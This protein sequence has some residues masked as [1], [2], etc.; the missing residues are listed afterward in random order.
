MPCPA[1]GEIVAVDRGDDDVRET[2]LAGRLGDVF[3]LGRIERAG[4]PGLDVAE[5]AGPRAGVAHDHE[6][7][8]LL[9]PALADIRAASFL[10]NGMQAIRAHDTLC[11]QVARRDRCLDSNP[12]RFAQG[13]LIRPMRLFRMT[14]PPG[15]VGHCVDKNSHRLYMETACGNWPRSKYLRLCL[16][17]R[18]F[19]LYSLRWVV[20]ERCAR[21]RTRTER[22]DVSGSHRPKSSVAQAGF[23]GKRW[24]GVELE[25][26]SSSSFMSAPIS[27]N[28]GVDR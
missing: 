10:A 15:G 1:V 13:R 5:G 23:G 27:P 24:F 12:L 11:V 2:E 14:G 17:R 22:G 6:G 9:L 19:R 20:N 7:G 3:R 26:A 4:Q 8:V 18:K 28:N 16:R 21:G 25:I